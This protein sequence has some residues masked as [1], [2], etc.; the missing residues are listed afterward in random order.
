MFVWNRSGCSYS[1]GQT[2]F[3]LN[4]G[5]QGAK[6]TWQVVSLADSCAMDF[7]VGIITHMILHVIGL[8]DELKRTD[9]ND[10]IKVYPR[11]S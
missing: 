10:F 4:L 9:R 6:E 3:D 11:K 2:E 8:D 1:L 5:Y 7:D